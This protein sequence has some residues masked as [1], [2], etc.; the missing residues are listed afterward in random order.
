MLE[1][2]IPLILNTILLLLLV[3]VSSDIKADDFSDIL[4]QY[5]K[6]A[7]KIEF[8]SRRKVI[9][10][11]PKYEFVFINGV[12]QVDTMPEVLLAAPQGQLKPQQALAPSSILTPMTPNE[13][14]M[15]QVFAEAQSKGPGN[16]A[17]NA[18]SSPRGTLIRPGTIPALPLNSIGD[19]EEEE[20]G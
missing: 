15:R 9:W 6:P 12:L 1:R 19:E 18:A 10:K 20:E 11:Y 7:E 2:K 4:S 13:D 14:I 16:S 3:V 8:E 5:G 17:P